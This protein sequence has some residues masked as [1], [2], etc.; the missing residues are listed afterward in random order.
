MERVTFD[1]ALHQWRELDK[2]QPS[3]RF[4][5]NPKM[6][7]GANVHDDANQRGARHCEGCGS[8]IGTPGF[9]RLDFP[10]GHP[11]FGQAI[12]C[13]RCNGRDPF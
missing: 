7:E 11:S 13:P 3:M 10:V 4:P 1:E 9:V 8:P 5:Y 2:G 6:Y 12:P